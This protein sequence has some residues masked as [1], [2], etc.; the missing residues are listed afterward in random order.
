MKTMIK[1]ILTLFLLVLGSYAAQAQVKIGNNPTSINGGSLLELESTNKG[2]LMPRISLTNTTTWGLS[3]TAVAGM[4]VYNTNAS[5]TSTTATCPTLSAKIGE[6]Y[7]DGSCWIAIA[8]TGTQD[9]EVVLRVEAVAQTIS[10]AMTGNTSNQL[11]NFS[12]TKFDKGS[13]FNLTTDLF[14]A[15]STG[16]YQINL[17]ISCLTVTGVQTG[18]AADLIINGVIDR[19]LFAN[20]VG[21]GEGFSSTT[22]ALLKLNAGDTIKINVGANG[23]VPWPLS[24]AILEIIKLSN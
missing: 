22:P 9:A 12:T 3:G 18:R 14:T 1:Q 15:P 21:A 17:N 7:W 6:Y 24:K 8:G 13:N 16:Y 23:G 4:H 5:I 20:Q 19:Q 11:L 10:I 2:L